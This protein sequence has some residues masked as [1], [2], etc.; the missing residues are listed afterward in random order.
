MC[1]AHSSASLSGVSPEVDYQIL[2]KQPA[3]IASLS[4]KELADVVISAVRL[5]PKVTVVSR[6]VDPIWDLWPFFE[7]A[8]VARSGKRIVWERLVPQA[9]TQI[10][11]RIIYAYWREGLNGIRPAA[12]TLIHT[13][14]YCGYFLK[15]L[16]QLG[17]A[18]LRDVHPLIATTYAHQVSQRGITPETQNNYLMAVEL[19][20]HFRLV[21]PHERLPSHPWVGRSACELSGY[22]GAARQRDVVKTPLISLA[23]L[24]KQITF[25]EKVIAEADGTLAMRDAGRLSQASRKVVLIRDA[26]FYSLGLSCGARVEELVAVQVGAARTE[27]RKGTVLHWLRSVEAKTGQGVVEYLIPESALELLKLL[28]RWSAPLR[29]E[30]KARIQEL[31][32]LLVH[33]GSED[34]ELL[35]ELCKAKQDVSRLFLGKAPAGRV[36]AVS[37]GAC[38]Q[39]MRKFAVEC[40]SETP[41]NPRQLRR[42][43]AWAWV[44]TPRGELRFLRQQLHHATI[45]RTAQYAAN[46]HADPSLVQELLEEER[47]FNT[48]LVSSWLEDD[49]P[50]A[51]GAGA[52]IVE[53]RANTFDSREAMVQNTI[54]ELTIRSTGH[55]WCLAR[56]EGCGGA[57]LYEQAMCA[58]CSGG[59]I[60]KAFHGAWKEIYWHQS[61]LVEEGAEVY[62]RAAKEKLEKDLLKT[63]RVLERLGLYPGET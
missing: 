59:V 4:D 23:D 61:Q 37:N 58:D 39:M 44:R 32:S 36:T 24:K 15:Y 31:E 33:G 63:K 19:L 26:C 52:K 49:E 7:Q 35:A 13:T 22:S 3:A 34:P 38:F 25:S 40:G 14:K 41:L 1:A 16:S 46:P 18:S 42:T 56:E 8:A 54:A 28:E 11:K 57:G 55:S 20:W 47:E 29:V 45:V 6:Y 5:G 53:M 10:A 9:F 27:K 30:L 51:G 62:G 48:E 12:I 43:H 17:M 60:D 50:L 21:H 2:E